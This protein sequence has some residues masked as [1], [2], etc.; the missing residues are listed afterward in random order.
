MFESEHTAAAA[1]VDRMCAAAR[2][3]N[4]AAGQRL[5]AIGEL[6]LL[7]LR[8]A[9][10]CESWLTDTWEAISAEVAAALRI[11]QGLASSYLDYSRAM[12]IR[13][14]QV[15]AALAAGDISYLMFQTIVYRTEL[16][17]DPDV[18]AAVDDD[19]AV[20]VRRWPSMT[21]GRLAGYIDQ[22]VARVDADAVRRRK[23]TQPDR[24]LSIWD[25][26]NG[27]TEVFGRL[28]SIDGHVVDARLDV[29][30]A[31]VCANDPR[32]RNQRRADALGALAAGADRLQCRCRQ[33]D[34]QADTT[35]LPR[36]V[37]V[38]VVADQATLEGSADQPGSLVGTDALITA[39]VI[40]EL[41]DSARLQPLIHPLD[42]S[43]E[44]G[45]TP[46]SALADFVRC[47]DLTCR[48]PGCD[49]PAMDCDVDHTIPHATGGAT[50][51]SNLKCLCRK[52]HLV[53]TFWGWRDRQLPDG[54][55][56]WNAPSG[57][58][59]VTTPG[60]ALLFPG[61]CAPTAELPAL[62]PT[63]AQR[64]TDRSLMMPK[65]RRTRAQNRAD[66]IATERRH[67]RDAR[68]A[69]ETQRVAT[70]LT[71]YGPPPTEDDEPPPF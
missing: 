38:H 54:T 42:A 24:E 41:A 21:R 5:I 19:L 46:S 66:Y 49:R 15:G 57:H 35:P 23:K 61:L 4:K 13:L 56:I 22:V 64:C 9:E 67:N 20:R 32:T 65:R 1:L 34:C 6:D 59:Y 14:P 7:R 18:L 8:E 71:S 26:G 2:A 11:S 55:V 62:H 31:T 48:F 69:R 39:E 52:H 33:P 10:E 53:K 25:S 3:E 28:A 60:S 40:A 63:S 12:R 36:P 70:Q 44:R 51:A 16:I 43:P 37:V 27:L 50:H 58:T 47:R 45:Y 17:T 30:A 29:L 68:Q